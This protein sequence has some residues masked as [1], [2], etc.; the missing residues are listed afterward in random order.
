M[1]IWKTDL[2]RADWG[3]IESLCEEALTTQSK[4]LQLAAWLTEAW[5][6]LR[7]VE[8]YTRGIQLFSSLIEAFWET[9]H[10]QPPEDG[11][12]EGRLMIFEWMDRTLSAR[13]LLIPL[14]QSQFEET[15]FGLGFFKSAQHNDAAQRRA[16]GK[17]SSTNDPSKAVGTIEDFQR[18]LDQTPDAYL[19]KHHQTITQALQATRTLKEG[20]SALLGAASPS[21]SQILGTLQEMDRILKS[22]LQTREPP[23][24]VED[25]TPDIMP[26]TDSSEEIPAPTADLSA[27]PEI[28]RR[29]LDL[30]NRDDAYRHLETIAA[31]L[32]QS[33]PHSLAPQLLRQLLRWEHRNI[34]NILEE[35]A[36][37]PQEYDILMKLF[38]SF[39]N[40][41]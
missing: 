21:F 33:D 34:L 30:K 35:I 19:S 18:S 26:G 4:D 10:P 7:G 9:L 13:L 23:P 20:L 40:S 8:G 1:G 27:V 32:E 38:G 41:P 39:P 15:A 5:I 2:R 11:D 17:A 14:T 25:P 24:P 31:F 6:S 36:K 16:T 12:M 28:S 3:K 29:K 37:T 22:A